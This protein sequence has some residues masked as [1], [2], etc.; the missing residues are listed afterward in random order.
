M[1]TY[2]ILLG[3]VGNGLLLTRGLV[4]VILCGSIRNSGMCLPLRVWHC[5]SLS[6]SKMQ[7]ILPIMLYGPL[8]LLSCGEDEAARKLIVLTSFIEPLSCSRPKCCFN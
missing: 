3:V 5:R 4:A 6:I 8:V 7:R 2:T 1:S